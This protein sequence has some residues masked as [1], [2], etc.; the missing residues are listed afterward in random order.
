MEKRTKKL[1]IAVLCTLLLVFSVVNMCVV[2]YADEIEI[3]STVELS[4][5]WTAFGIAFVIA[6]IAVLVMKS[7]M[8]NV[9]G[10]GA[11]SEYIIR[12]S[13]RIDHTRDSFMYSTLTKTKIQRDDDDN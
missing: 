13:I 3:E 11:A 4:P 2:A 8:K 7:M 6:L 9:R 5:F 10:T 12:D 1:T